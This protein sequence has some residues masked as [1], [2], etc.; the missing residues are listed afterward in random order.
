MKMRQPR[1]SSAV[2]KLTEELAEPGFAVQG[3]GTTQDWKA[4]PAGL[5]GEE[6]ARPILHLS[7]LGAKRG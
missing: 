1:A 3:Q 6:A 4:H 7:H 2:T 5:I